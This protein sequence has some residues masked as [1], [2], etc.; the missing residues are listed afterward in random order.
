MFNKPIDE[1]KGLLQAWHISNWKDEPHIEGAYSYDMVE[2][3]KARQ[4]LIK[5]INNSVFFAGEGLY[6]GH[7]PG[8]V[9]AALSTGKDVAK[10][11]M[12]NRVVRL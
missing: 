4:L 12:S 3:K 11:I 6:E 7:A 8:T 10:L 5:P 9:E 2:S 1:L